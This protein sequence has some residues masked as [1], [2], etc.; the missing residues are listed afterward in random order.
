MCCGCGAET[1]R[2]KAESVWAWDDFEAG[3]GHWLHTC[4]Q[5][6]MTRES[7]PTIRA[8]KAWIFDNSGAVASVPHA[9]MPFFTLV[10]GEHPHTS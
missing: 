2:F 4:A 10:I 5:C 9:C 3:E 6:I 8:A 1:K 7:L